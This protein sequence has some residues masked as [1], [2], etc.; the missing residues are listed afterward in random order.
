MS[1]IDIPRHLF[2]CIYN[3]FTPHSLTF[4]LFY[5]SSLIF[6]FHLFYFRP[7]RV[8][9]TQSVNNVDSA[10]HFHHG[11]YGHEFLVNTSDQSVEPVPATNPNVTNT[12][13]ET[14]SY[15]T[16]YPSVLGDVNHQ[17]NS[18]SE[19]SVCSLNENKK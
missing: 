16:Y 15:S 5:F 1:F 19:A 2:T 9:I 3:T 12:D 7:S 17:T 14:S 8:L 18:S 11:E 6:C 10:S 13:E 4:T